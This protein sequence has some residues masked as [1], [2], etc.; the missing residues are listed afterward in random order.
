MKKVIITP[1]LVELGDEE[2]NFNY[3]LGLAAAKVSDIIILVGKERSVP[4]C[5]AVATTDFDKGNLFV[6]SSFKEALE[7]YTTVCDENTVVLIENDLPDNY[8]K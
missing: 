5:D 3:K 8:L 4:M 7:V 6:V 1:G 2:Y